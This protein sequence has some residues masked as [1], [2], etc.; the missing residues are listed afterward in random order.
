MEIQ[1]G[2]DWTKTRILVSLLPRKTIISHSNAPE[3]GE[4]DVFV[5]IS[6]VEQ[7]EI[8]PLDQGIKLTFETEPDKKGKG[9]KAVNLVIVD[10]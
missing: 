8:A 10:E 4:T 1:N 3:D 5:H 6:A 2:A 9:D 7:S